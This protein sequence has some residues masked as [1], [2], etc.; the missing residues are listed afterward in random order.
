MRRGKYLYCCFDPDYSERAASA[1][2]NSS[3]RDEF[4][5]AAAPTKSKTSAFSVTSVANS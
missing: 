1:A 4:A 5:A 2:N 3:D